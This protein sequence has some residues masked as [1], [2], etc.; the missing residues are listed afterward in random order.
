VNAPATALA[1]APA[2]VA[3]GPTQPL[4]VLGVGSPLVD[5][6]ASATDEQ[7]AAADL[8]KGSMALVD[9]ARAESIYESMGTTVEVSGGS[10][11]NTMAGVAALGGVAGFVGKVADDE[12]GKVFIHDIAAS[13]VEFHPVVAASADGDPGAAD[14]EARGT[15]RC[16]VLVAEDA[17]RTMAT[18]LGVATTIGPDDVPAAMVGRAEILYLEGYLWDLPP[19]K[20]AMRRAIGIAHDHEGSVALSL[21]DPF[22]VERHQREFLD[23]VRDDVDVLFGNEEEVTRLFGASSLSGAIDAAEETGVLVALTLGAQGSVVM[24]PGGPRSVPAA[25][26]ER[27]LDTTG[28]GDLYAAGFLYGLTHGASPEVCAQLGGL[29]AAE[30]ISHL[31]AR[32]QED[33]RRLAADAGL[34]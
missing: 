7:L 12:L 6:L 10:A 20:E 1:G 15:G 34:L 30:V 3:T 25:P 11:A 27:V 33:L 13:G 23:L 24:T 29:C 14:A 31:G 18:H 5:V 4:H 2:E 28:A 8:V 9:L 22:C 32:P 26:V 17:E 21:S 19:A 16:L